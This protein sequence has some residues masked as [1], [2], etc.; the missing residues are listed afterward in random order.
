MG[1]S[2]SKQSP[3]PT[4][5]MTNALVADP[6][7]DEKANG[8]SLKGKAKFQPTA[9]YANNDEGDV[10]AGV[11]QSVVDKWDAV[12]EKVGCGCITANGRTPGSSSP[13]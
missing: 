5:K 3:P 9:A 2:F 10:A 12:L 8:Q 6:V 13:V 11:D 4:K 1:G 7:V